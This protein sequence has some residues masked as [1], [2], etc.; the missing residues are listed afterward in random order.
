MSL[1]ATGVL[2]TTNRW[3]GSEDVVAACS[4]LAGVLC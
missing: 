1:H 2:K 3:N 4:R